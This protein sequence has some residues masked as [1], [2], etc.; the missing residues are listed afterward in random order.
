MASTEEYQISVI[1]CKA[2]EEV[3]QALPIGLGIMQYYAKVK[4]INLA[5]FFKMA[6]GFKT[7]ASYTYLFKIVL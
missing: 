4:R 1:F 2:K 5:S 7:M 6:C 3:Y